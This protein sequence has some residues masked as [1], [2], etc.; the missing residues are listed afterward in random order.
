M[1][2]KFFEAFT[3]MERAQST[4]PDD[5][6]KQWAQIE[7]DDWQAAGRRCNWKSWRATI[8]GSV[9]SHLPKII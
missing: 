6:E 4:K 3:S 7:F 2:N 5:Y 1:V 9:L 8:I